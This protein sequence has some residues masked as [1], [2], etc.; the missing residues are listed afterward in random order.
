MATTTAGAGGASPAAPRRQLTLLDSTS[1]IV[2]IIIGSSIYESAPLIAKSLPSTAWL[3]GMWVLGG[4]LSLIGALC[5]AELATAYPTEGGAYVYL[6]RAF[7]R[8]LGFLF[9]WAQFWVV[10]PGSIGAMSYVFARYANQLWHLGEGSSPLIAYAVGAILVL[11]GVNLLG[12]QPGKWTQN[13][14]TVVKF[15]GLAAVVVAGFYAGSPR[16]F[17]PGAGP[18]RSLSLD[19]LSLAM[20]LIFYAYGGWNEMAYVGAE[21]RNPQKNILRALVLGTV[22]VAS[23]YVML[24][25]AFVYALGL[26]GTAGSQVVAA[27]V[28]EKAAEKTAA[29]RAAETPDAQWNAAEDRRPD[30]IARARSRAGGLISGL[31]CISALGA[32]NGMI[33]TGARIYYAMGMEHRL[34]AWLGQWSARRDAPIRSLL[35]QGLVTVVLAV[36]FGLTPNGFESSVKF[37][38]PVFWAFFFLVGLGLFVLRYREPGQPRPYRVP[39]YPLTPIVFCLCSL[40]MIYTS[41]TFAVNNKTYEALWAVG[42]LAV[43]LVLSYFDPQRRVTA[44]HPSR[45]P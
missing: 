28:V 5:Y 44:A 26:D 6:T 8:K 13:V 45:A 42:L 36:G 22:A 25:L 18:P 30:H 20:I 14:L 29:D 12:V 41:L 38:T 2:G 17:A 19:G 4:V 39:L 33:F 43:G 23:L 9:G 31:I 35:I 3:L 7:G 27:S 15:A 37:T 10:R 21:V 11:T 24:N 16:N 1:I 34:Y 40:F 32:I